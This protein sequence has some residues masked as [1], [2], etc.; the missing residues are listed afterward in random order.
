MIAQQSVTAAL[1]PLL[2]VSPAIGRAFTEA[3]DVGRSSSPSSA[4]GISCR[5]SAAT[6]APS[7]ESSRSTASRTRSSA[8]CPTGFA[9][10]DPDADIWVTMGFTE[11]SRE[12]RGRY[13][14]TIGRLKPGLTVQGAQAE[15]AGIMA[16]L[17]RKFPGSTPAGRRASSRC[18][19]R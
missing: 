9:L 6:R 11:R 14:T 19:S 4:T 5:G 10:L 12:P 3:E 18:T 16:E 7:D 8:S 15:M 13:L 1:F 17:T 2:G